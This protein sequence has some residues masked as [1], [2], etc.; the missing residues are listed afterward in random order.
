M[1]KIKTIAVRNPEGNI[2][3]FYA[4]NAIG[5]TEKRLLEKAEKIRAKIGGTI[6]ICR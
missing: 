6:T 5:T 1:Y 2:V 3:A 4:P